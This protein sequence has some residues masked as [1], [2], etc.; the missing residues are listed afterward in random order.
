MLIAVLKKCSE[1]SLLFAVGNFQL[2]IR[3]D[4]LFVVVIA[5]GLDLL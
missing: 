1:R 3:L 4:E 5:H 2:F